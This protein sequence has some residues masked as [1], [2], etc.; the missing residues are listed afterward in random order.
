MGLA[1]NVGFCSIPLRVERV[2]VLLKPLI[3]RDARIDR[4]AN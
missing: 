3:C 4:T 2:E 1:A